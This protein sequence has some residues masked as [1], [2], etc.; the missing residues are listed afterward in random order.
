MSSHSFVSPS[1]LNKHLKKCSKR[2]RVKVVSC[3]F[4]ML[5]DFQV[6]DVTGI[7]S[8]NLCDRKIVPKMSLADVSAFT[9]L[10]LIAR[11]EE[12][13]TGQI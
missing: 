13:S 2:R 12:L 1:N 5:N 6:Y 8:A 11:L 4:I 7:N 3:C 9:T 10:R